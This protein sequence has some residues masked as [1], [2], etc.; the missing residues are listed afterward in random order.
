MALSH[1]VILSEFSGPDVTFY[2]DDGT[3][4]RAQGSLG[5]GGGGLNGARLTFPI[6]WAKQQIPS[7]LQ[8]T[9]EVPVPPS[10]R[11]CS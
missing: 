5:E 1:L 8:Q 6:H 7:H 10:P 11:A 4:G 9:G 2:Q 3:L